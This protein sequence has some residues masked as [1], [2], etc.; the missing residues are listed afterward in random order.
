MLRCQPVTEV[1]YGKTVLCQAHAIILIAFLIAVN[2]A[3]SMHTDDNR[4]CSFP[5]F[6]PVDVQLV[7]FLIRAVPDIVKAQ[8]ILGCCQPFIP[9]VVTAFE[10]CP[11]H[12][13]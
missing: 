2:P 3:S 11:Q 9:L 7:P 1:H 12:H 5:V 13:A 6:G 8:D 10:C 4:E